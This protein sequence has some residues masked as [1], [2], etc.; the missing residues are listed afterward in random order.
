MSSD[1]LRTSYESAY[2]TTAGIQVL[3][4]YMTGNAANSKYLFEDLELT[5]TAFALCISQEETR[6]DINGNRII[7]DLNHMS[8][9]SGLTRKSISE[10]VSHVNGKILP[11]IIIPPLTITPI[12]KYG[13][14]LGGLS[15]T[16]SIRVHQMLLWYQKQ[17]MKM[18]NILDML[19]YYQRIGLGT[20]HMASVDKS[21]YEIFIKSMPNITS[22]EGCASP[23]DYINPNYCSP[24]QLDIEQFGSKGS[25]FSFLTKAEKPY[26][27]LLHPP[28][29]KNFVR[30][31]IT[32]VANYLKKFYSQG[33]AVVYILPN[34]DSTLEKY[35]SNKG[36]KAY[37]MSDG[38]VI[39]CTTNVPDVSKE[40][41]RVITKLHYSLSTETS[42]C[43][44]ID[45][46][47]YIDSN[48]Q[49][50]IPYET[51]VSCNNM[52][53]LLSSA[54]ISDRIEY[55]YVS[56]FLSIEHIRQLVLNDTSS[57]FLAQ[58]IVS[59]WATDV[60]D[61]RFGFGGSFHVI[62]YRDDDY[63]KLGIITDYFTGKAR[64][65]GQL[66][67]Y[68]P[69]VKAWK[70]KAVSIA[71]RSIEYVKRNKVPLS[72]KVL[73][74][75]I[76][77]SKILMCTNFK[78]S[79]AMAIYRI[80]NSLTIQPG[81][82]DIDTSNKA[83]GKLVCYDPFGGWGDRAIGASLSGVVSK[84]ICTDSNERLADGYGKIKSFFEEIQPSCEI[85]QYITP[86]EDFDLEVNL[87]PTVDLV[88]S[89]PPYFNVETYSPCKG[90][91]NIDHPEFN[92]WMNWFI[93]QT[94][95]VAR[96]LRQNGFLVYYLAN[97]VNDITSPLIQALYESKVLDFV[98]TLP[99]IREDFDR[100]P[101]LLYVWR[102]I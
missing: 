53:S 37:R 41:T 22:I 48:R 5:V 3:Y 45:I 56:S 21:I 74:E 71:T 91:S 50:F 70:D 34:P 96:K 49:I 102:K 28:L 4:K 27:L 84:Y 89:G 63:D 13:V 54:I 68:N 9:K 23:L 83:S 17:G 39:Y 101:I 35:V 94:L 100:R 78:I 76:Y 36:M 65:E 88:F 58:N 66:F 82:L 77:L 73:S 12:D 26:L 64:A 51:V 14:I 43:S 31:L 46:D 98:G 93:T 72:A 75:A 20:K 85:T 92:D 10:L 7:L 8:V 69:P 99:I 95:R 42:T 24:R 6:N 55:P 25:I 60:P 79:V 29:C 19:C 80:F 47:S 1:V 86:V 18:E 33:A 61:V 52:T 16:N 2:R 57:K 97:H 40:F 38:R 32:H 81:V 15:F 30:V 62:T 59:L 90:Q 67:T 44:T 87:P 11:N